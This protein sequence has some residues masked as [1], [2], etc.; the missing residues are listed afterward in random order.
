[1]YI[2]VLVFEIK[3]ELYEKLF[4]KCLLL[5]FNKVFIFKYVY[6]FCLF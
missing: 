2:D 1:M 3:Y 5:L 6:C 4:D